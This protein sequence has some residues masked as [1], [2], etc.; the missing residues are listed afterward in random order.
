MEFYLENPKATE[1]FGRALGSLLPTCGVLCLSGDLGTG[2]TTLTKGIA[3]ALGVAP[4]EVL[5]PT[6]TL[7]NV[8]QSEGG[9]LYHFDLYR[10]E[11]ALE[12]DDIGFDEYIYGDGISIVE[13]ADL[14]PERLPE[15]ALYI[16]LRQE[17]DG[18]KIVL[19]STNPAWQQI[20]KRLKD[21]YF[22]N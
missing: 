17:G 10:L 3:A 16:T 7:M 22:R 6:F 14:F 8:Y 4:D 13:W 20:L 11:D 18:R 9:E 5:S 12:L 19:T 2:K 1:D 21:E 15:D